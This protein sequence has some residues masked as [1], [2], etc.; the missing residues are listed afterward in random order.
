VTVPVGPAGTVMASYIRKDD[1]TT[2]N[3]DAQQW[4][5]GYSQ[6]LSKRTSAYVAYAKIKNKNGAGY[7][8]GNNTEVGSGDKAFNVG[9]RHSF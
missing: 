2:N 3:Q 5:L 8:V 1:K 7:T 6:A 9:M 4:A